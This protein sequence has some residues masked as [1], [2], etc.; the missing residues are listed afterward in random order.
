MISSSSQGEMSPK[1]SPETSTQI[2]MLFVDDEPSL[3]AGTRRALYGMQSQWNMRFVNSGPEALSALREHPADVVVS[4]MR[5]P[6][7]DGATLLGHVRSEFPDTVRIVLSGYSD[8]GDALRSVPICHEFLNKPCRPDEL[9]AAVARAL[10]LQSRLSKP[11]LRRLLSSLGTLPSPT[12]TI[13]ALNACLASNEPSVG[14]VTNLVTE[15]V[16]MT[17]RLLQVVNSALFGLSNKVVDVGSAI[18]YLG[19]STVRDLTAMADMF[20]SFSGNGSVSEGLLDDLERHAIAVAQLANSLVSDHHDR[21]IAY[22]AGLLHDIGELVIATQLPESLE[23]I[24]MLAVK[25]PE[26]T[27]LDIEDEVLGATHADIGAYLLT[28][29]GLP[30]DIVDAVARHHDAEVYADRK[31]SALH[32]VHVAESVISSGGE[33]RFALSK[34]DP[35]YIEDLGLTQRLREVS[36]DLHAVER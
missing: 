26:R 27:Q 13:D 29:W 4:D 17:A 3:L 16:A 35:G 15:D 5:M 14:D 21:Q 1:V 23:Q 12:A 8:I 20:R 31:L 25:D 36:H 7:M 9:K 28:Q 6:G 24:N 10:E 18:T 11:Q 30:Y 19:L 32:A 33:Y 34:L 2:E 22:S